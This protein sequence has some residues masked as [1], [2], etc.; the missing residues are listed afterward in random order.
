MAKTEPRAARIKAATTALYGERGQTKMAKS[1][2][3]SKQMLSF[4]LAGERPVT[5]DVEDKVVEALGREIE[6]LGKTTTKL[7]EIQGRILAAREK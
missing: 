4:L 6:R 7:M 1:I 5:D 2:G 3:I